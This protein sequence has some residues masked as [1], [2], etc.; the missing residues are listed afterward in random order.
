MIR[1][2]IFAEE[3]G[4]NMFSHFIDLSNYQIVEVKL[5]WWLVVLSVLFAIIAT[6]TALSLYERSKN[7]SFLDRKT[8]ILGASFAMAYGIWSMHY[9]GMMAFLLPVKITYH[10]GLT[11]G[12]MIPIV[13]SSYLAFYLI[14][15][16]KLTFVKSF[17]FSG[18]M[19]L[20]VSTMHWLGMLSMQSD[21]MHQ[22]N[23]SGIVVSYLVSFI[24]FLVLCS[25]YQHLHK[26]KI[27][28]VVSL[29]VG[30]AVSAT[31]YIAKFSM[32][33]YASKDTVFLEQLVI[34][35]DRLFLAA[36]LTAGLLSMTAFLIVWTLYDF[37]IIGKSKEIDSITQLP[38]NQQL[39]K[40]IQH[41]NYS[42]MAVLKFFDLT[43]INRSYGYHIGDLYVQYVANIVKR[44]ASKSVDI[45]RVTSNQFLLATERTDP[46]FKEKLNVI[47]QNFY[48]PFVAGDISSKVTGVCGYAST[49]LTDE[50]LMDC[51]TAIMRCT[52]LP[53]DF[54]I[55]HYDKNEHDVD[56]QFE[57][58][59]SVNKAMEDRDLY[60]VYQ[61]KI[62]SQTGRL[63]GAE[64]L[65]RW[66]HKSLGFLNPGQFIPILEM[67]H[68]MGE[69]TN[70]IIGEV[71]AQLK[72]WDNMGINL[73]HVSVNIPGDYLTSPLLIESV[74]Y[75]VEKYGIS[76]ERLEL[77][78][79]ETS[80]VEN[81]EKG[82]R[83]VNTFRN[84]GFSVALDDFGTGLS[85]LS[86][87]RQMQITTLKIDKSFVDHIPHSEKDT[88]I[89]LAIVSLGQSLKLKVV[90]EGVETREQVDF[91][92]AN[93]A[94][95]I[96]QGYYFSRPLKVEEFENEYL[97]V[98]N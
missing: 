25:F 50:D 42:Q 9:M 29:V 35:S 38:N 12:S 47:I 41:K 62:N 17:I 44:M 20:G 21:L 90:V 74:K 39:L 48:E 95:P 7:Y 55:V 34:S 36:F 26:E 8:W 85:S 70:W 76:P 92:N 51:I 71:C 6:Y 59:K 78:I 82:M 1:W 98:T 56:L 33:Y 80:F 68:K 19:S 75:N 54:S 84:Q 31:H 10:I 49:A 46:S 15:Q 5:T 94:Q 69:V 81:L 28:I 22:M 96:I 65:L 93:C 3:R 77:E 97:F 37:Y 86:Y 89:F 30:L 27:R 87:L 64:A 61:P 18:F 53:D 4:D 67:N 60:L 13:V 57:V 24:G 73:P 58:L 79:T 16:S 66:Q 23:Y 91:I 52:T 43:S 11:I 83:A 45:Y 40:N 72:Q 88:A 63:E 14:N 32:V 2:T